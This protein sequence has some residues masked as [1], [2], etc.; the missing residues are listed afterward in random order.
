MDRKNIIIVEERKSFFTGDDGLRAGDLEI[1]FSF[2][3][4]FFLVV[5]GIAMNFFFAEMAAKVI[6]IIIG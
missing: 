6:I 3:Y 4:F 2:L 5:F 1:F